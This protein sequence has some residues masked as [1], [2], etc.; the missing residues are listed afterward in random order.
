MFSK[1]PLKILVLGLVSQAE[2]FLTFSVSGVEYKE[3]TLKT[4][5]NH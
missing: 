2:V 3:S 4:G 5:P 1:F